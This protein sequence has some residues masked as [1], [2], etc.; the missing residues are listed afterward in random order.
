[1]HVSVQTVDELG[2][3]DMKRVGCVVIPLLLGLAVVYTCVYHDDMKRNFSKYMKIKPSKKFECR[4]VLHNLTIGRWEI[5]PEVNETDVKRI[6][7][8]FIKVW[9]KRQIPAKRWR[10]DGRCGHY[11]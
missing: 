6:D 2:A 4:N 8:I 10:E 11:K 3:V 9:K 1:M 5:L 7:D